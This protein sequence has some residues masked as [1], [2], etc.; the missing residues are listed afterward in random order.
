MLYVLKVRKYVSPLDAKE[1]VNSLE[2]LQGPPD[3]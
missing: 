1:R 2:L 3:L